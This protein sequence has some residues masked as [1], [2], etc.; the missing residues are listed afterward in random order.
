MVK[1]FVYGRSDDGLQMRRDF[2]TLFVDGPRIEEMRLNGS[3]L[4]LAKKGSL[5][6][7]LRAVGSQEAMRCQS[8]LAGWWLTKGR[9]CRQF[10]A[11]GKESRSERRLQ[12]SRGR[13]AGF[14]RWYFLIY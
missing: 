1:G 12:Q 2:E 13:R 14:V 8:A 11:T 6:P 3:G 4:G 7:I 5:A 9:A 10:G